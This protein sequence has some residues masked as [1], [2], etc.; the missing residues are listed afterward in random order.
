LCVKGRYGW[1][2]SASPQRLTVPLIR[3]DSAYPKGPLSADVRGDSDT[4][5]GYNDRGRVNG[6]GNRSGGGRKDGRPGKDRGRKPGGLVDYD[7]VMPF[8]R[9]APSPGS[10]RRSAPTRRPTSS[11]SSSAPASARTTSTTAPGSATPP[12][13]S[14]C[15]RAS[16]PGR[17]PPPTGTWSTPTA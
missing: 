1:D 6:G 15:S 4:G 2:Y 14:R 10:A 17:C 11:R 8:F 9:E 12:R 16:A 13:C 3:I 7:E 5:A